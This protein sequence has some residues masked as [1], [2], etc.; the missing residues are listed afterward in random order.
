MLSMLA[1]TT[2]NLRMVSEKYFKCFVLT[3]PFRIILFFKRIVLL[4]GC[5]SSKSSRLSN[6]KV[7]DFIYYR[8]NASL[9]RD[10]IICK[11]KMSAT[12][13]NKRKD[14][15]KARNSTRIIELKT[16]QILDMRDMI[17]CLIGYMSYF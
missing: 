13:V 3:I 7:M 11:Y 10:R 1:G 16:E 9:T 8:T 17:T 4:P 2:D 6:S 12:I 14:K 15:K 5:H